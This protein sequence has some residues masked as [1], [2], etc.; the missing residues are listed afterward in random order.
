MVFMFFRL[1]F[2]TLKDEVPREA[3]PFPH[4]IQIVYQTVDL[5]P[6]V[7]ILPLSGGN[8]QEHIRVAELGS[9]GV[10]PDE[11]VQDFLQVVLL[12]EEVVDDGVHV[13]KLPQ[14]H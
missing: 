13:N 14:A 1:K 2:I 5:L 8:R 12:L 9:S 3:E 4:L 10:D 11:D 7:P 6:G